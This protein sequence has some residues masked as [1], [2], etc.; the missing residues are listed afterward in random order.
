[1]KS[2]EKVNEIPSPSKGFYAHFIKS[3]D[4]HLVGLWLDFTGSFFGWYEAN[5]ATYLK[6]AGGA[7]S[8]NSFKQLEFIYHASRV[9]NMF[10]GQYANNSIKEFHIR[11]SS[12]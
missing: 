10:R 7:V 11:A 1:M 3:K 4:L 2:S 8:W 12:C 6:V 5:K 9:C